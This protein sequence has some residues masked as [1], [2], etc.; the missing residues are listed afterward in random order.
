M[1]PLLILKASSS[2]VQLALDH[3]MTVICRYKA[4]F[5][6]EFRYLC[7]LYMLDNNSNQKVSEMFV[8][9]ANVVQP[10]ENGIC[11]YVV[12]VNKQIKINCVHLFLISVWHIFFFF[13]LLINVFTYKSILH[14]LMSQ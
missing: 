7:I 11:T 3:H 4:H 13:V 6:K 9:I 2:H 10:V 5:R 8:I 14:R 12:N 1:F